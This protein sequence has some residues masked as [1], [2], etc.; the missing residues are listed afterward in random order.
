MAIVLQQDQRKTDSIYGRVFCQGRYYGDFK[1]VLY[2]GAKGRFK[3]DVYS[4]MESDH[5]EDF[6]DVLNR[7]GTLVTTLGFKE[8]GVCG[9]TILVGHDGLAFKASYPTFLKLRDVFEAGDNC[10]VIRDPLLMTI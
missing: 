5:G 6:I 9:S 2:S 7:D 1:V 4:L 10:L 8:A 3:A